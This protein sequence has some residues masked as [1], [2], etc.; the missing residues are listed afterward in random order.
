[1]CKVQV[2]KYQISRLE[3]MQ[4]TNMHSKIHR[5]Q[6]TICL[7]YGEWGRKLILVFVSFRYEPKKFSKVQLQSEYRPWWCLL[8]LVMKNSK[9]TEKLEMVFDCTCMFS[10]RSLNDMICRGPD[11]TAKSMCMF[12]RF[13]KTPWP[14]LNVWIKR[15]CKCM[16]LSQNVKFLIFL[17]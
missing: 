13:R 17:W 6:Q 3:V 5:C 9:N 2:F 4:Y 11:T 12:L 8:H 1:M 7:S 14:S 10:G 15:L 16:C